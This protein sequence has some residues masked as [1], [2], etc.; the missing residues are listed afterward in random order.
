MNKQYLVTLTD[1]ER[2]SLRGLVSQG[3]A[4]ARAI[5]HARILLKA[6]VAEDWNDEEISQAYDVSIRT[7][8]R[9][10]KRFVEEGL[11]AALR[12]PR[13]PR[14]PR[15]LDGDVEAHLVALAC[16]D[17]PEGR[18]RW[19]VRLLAQKLVELGHVDSISHESVRTA[20]KKRAEALAEE[21]LVHPALRVGRIRLSDGGGAGAVQDA[22][23]SRIPAG[24]PGRDLEAIDLRDAR[25]RAEAARPRRP[26]RCR[27]QARGVRQ[28]FLIF[29][30]LRGWRHVVIRRQKS[31]LDWADVIAEVLEVHYPGATRVRLVVDDLNTH[32]GGSLYQAFPPER[33]RGLYERLEIHY[34]PKHGS[35]LD[36]AEIEL[37]ILMGQCL[38][39]RI[40]TDAELRREVAA[41]E[42]P[43]NRVGSKIDWRFTTPDAR[44]KLRK[45]YP[46]LKVSVGAGETGGSPQSNPTNTT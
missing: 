21:V 11:E 6:D 29:E 30:P 32:A 5:E 20:R 24:L 25:P 2:Q 45:L 7:V 4:A 10:R 1:D 17:P 9:V 43:R 27:L 15:K 40:G 44:I 16:S 42:R 37:S 26:L 31:A 38:N 12:P 41:W 3:K 39:R 18:A 8:E 28:L 23:R 34:T 35:W 33:A 36:M 19:T 14:P 22:V 13:V 46:T